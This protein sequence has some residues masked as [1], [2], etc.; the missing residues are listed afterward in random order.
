M[1]KKTTT[2]R[3]KQKTP[4]YSCRGADVPIRDRVSV[5]VVVVFCLPPKPARQTLDP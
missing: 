4:V 2:T 1:T 5:V 3:N